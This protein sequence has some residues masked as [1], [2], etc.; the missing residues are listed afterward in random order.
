[1]NHNAT[2]HPIQPPSTTR[3]LT[4]IRLACCLW[5]LGTS[6]PA[7]SAGEIYK[8]VDEN[9]KTHFSERRDPA[10]RAQPLQLKPTTQ[11][12]SEAANMPS[13]EYWQKHETQFRQRQ[14]EK[15]AAKPETPNSGAAKPRSRT[16]GRSDDTDESRCALARDVLSGS[17]RHQ[18]GEPI[19]KYDLET[20]ENDVRS[21]CMK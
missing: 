20:A 9:G 13:A 19:D 17:L 15:S 16:G 11:T 4:L 10:G 7:V 1:M 5:L 12:T 18:N 2:S 3:R 21:Y 8:W 14:A 6:L